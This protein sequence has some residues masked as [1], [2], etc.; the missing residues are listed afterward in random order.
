VSAAACARPMSNVEDE[1]VRCAAAGSPGSEEASLLAVVAGAPPRR[2]G[3]VPWKERLALGLLC[4]G[5]AAEFPWETV[6]AVERTPGEGASSCGMTGECCKLRWM[7]VPPRTKDCNR[8]CSA[9]GGDITAKCAAGVR[10]LSRGSIVMGVARKVP[11]SRTGGGEFAVKKTVDQR[12]L[13][14]S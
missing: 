8:S 11:L 7:A 9:G 3:L 2:D 12:K 4:G 1:E 10:L 14:D 13:E 5:V 6:E